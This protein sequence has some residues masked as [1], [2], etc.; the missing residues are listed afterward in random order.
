M[1][2]SVSSLLDTACGHS[3][4]FG[5]FSIFYDLECKRLKIQHRVKF[6][7]VRS[8]LADGT[9]QRTGTLHIIKKKSV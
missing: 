6:T 1:L 9:V 8:R 2:A 7:L 4:G 5:I 3:T